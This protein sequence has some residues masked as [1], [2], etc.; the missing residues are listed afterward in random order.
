MAE[1]DGSPMGDLEEEVRQ[2]VLP[3]S[4]IIPVYNAQS[5]LER[6]VKS[7]NSGLLP[8]EIIV[9]DDASVDESVQVAKRLA[10]SHRNIR[11]ISRPKNGGAAASRRDGFWAAQCD[12]VAFVDADDYIED[13]ALEEAFNSLNETNSD[14]CILQLWRSEGDRTFESIDLSKVPFPITGRD[15]TELTLGSWAIHPLGVARK[16]IYLKAYASFSSLS[17][18]ADELITRLAFMNARKVVSCQK[19]YYYVV[20]PQSTTNALH[21]RL[22]TVLDSDMWLLK[23]CGDCGFDKRGV[24]RHSMAELWRLFRQRR[25]IGIPETREKLRRFTHDVSFVDGFLA[26][27]LREPKALIK[28]F[29]VGIYCRLP[30]DAS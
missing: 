5:T 7:V 13:G 29:L 3:V 2:S 20:N 1:T 8:Q 15:A 9:V 21:P 25:E 17:M 30:F 27:I 6:C 16:D 10:E 24:L 14:L 12:H 19:R 11:I 18:N 23:F 22:L 28:F 26:G 4:V